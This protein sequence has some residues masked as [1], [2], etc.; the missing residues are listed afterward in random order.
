MLDDKINTIV[1]EANQIKDITFENEKIY[2]NITLAKIDKDYP[3]NKLTGAIFKV[4]EDTNKNGTFD[5][6]DKRG[7]S[8]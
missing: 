6:E 8:P 7:K 3:E 5:E 1:L 4:Y 2:G